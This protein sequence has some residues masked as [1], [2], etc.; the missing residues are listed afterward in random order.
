M[1]ETSPPSQS[2]FVGENEVKWGRGSR[3]L[4]LLAAVTV[5]GIGINLAIDVMLP[6]LFGFLFAAAAQPLVQLCERHKVP[7]TFAVVIGVASMIFLF[8][9][10]SGALVFGIL[11]LA[12]EMGRYEA[13][14]R[15]TQRDLT[16]YFGAHGFTRLAILIQ[17]QKFLEIDEESVGMLVDFSIRL[18][19]FATMAALVAFFG[20]LERESL[21]R[22]LS[23][24]SEYEETWRRVTLDT[25][26]YLG[27]KAVTSAITGILAAVVCL[28]ADL[29]NAALWGAVAFWF[30]FIP[31][32]G[33]IMA[34]VPPILV[35]LTI[36]SPQVA[37]LV[38]L[39]YVAIN[40]VFGNI[41][42]P[43]WQGRAAGMSPLVVILSIAI[44]GGLLGPM[45]ALVAIPLTMII[46]IG[47]FHTKDLSW[48]ARILGET[49]PGQNRLRS[50]I[51]SP[52]IEG[53][54]RASLFS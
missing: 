25:Q 54:E 24:G 10:A 52:N 29:P 13:G 48:I 11:D 8:L 23:N 44:W 22:R 32:V 27:I 30:N 46:K 6:I 53:Q 33:S 38:M 17:R 42:E 41:L 2:S 20:L 7:P 49:E 28:L 39:G 50:R 1:D 37:A 5:V 36:H 43:R 4:L 18:I 45:G 31:V 19:G 26:R 47:C 9:A 12:T 15:E 3:T 21:I 35:A 40:M 51:K 34:G 14:V 16:Q